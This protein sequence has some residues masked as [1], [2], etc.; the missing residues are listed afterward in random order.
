[1]IFWL[2]LA[3]ARDLGRPNGFLLSC[4]YGPGI[5]FLFDVKSYVRFA[6]NNTTKQFAL[7]SISL[8]CY[9]LVCTLLSCVQSMDIGHPNYAVRPNN[10]KHASANSGDLLI[11]EPLQACNNMPVSATDVQ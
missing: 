7:M 1:L 6:L 5:Q 8:T 3:F 10:Y 4:Y 2:A 9:V 11:R